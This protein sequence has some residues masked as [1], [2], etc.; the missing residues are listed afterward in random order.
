VERAEIIESTAL[1][2][3]Y[4]AGIGVGLWK[5]EDIIKNRTIDREFVPNMEKEKREKLYKNWIKA[6]KRSMHWED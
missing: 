4:L 6:V 2:A 5:K 3:A 1:G